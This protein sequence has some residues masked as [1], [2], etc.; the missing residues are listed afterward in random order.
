[1]AGARLGSAMVTAAVAAVLFTTIGCGS[2]PV[3]E[4]GPD[5][6]AISAATMRVRADGCGPRT[7]LG[8]GT[9]IVDGLVVTAAHVVAGAQRVEVVDRLGDTIASDVV[10]FDPELDVAALRPNRDV[11][12]PVPVRAERGRQG[13]NGLVALIAADG[14]VTMLEVD[15]LQ[16]VTIDTTDIYRGEPVRRNGL[17]VAVTVAPGDSGAMV[18]L[19]GGGAGIVWSRSMETSDQAWT[20]DL[21][22]ELLDAP[23][24]RALGTPVDTG[25]CR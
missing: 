2:E 9:V 19:P 16:R 20:V 4:P 15:V 21:P 22:S 5:R 13:D 18:H 23:L 7:E 6:Q 8:T 25:P 3:S 17:R 11:G 1:M 12:P 24:R 10:L 14:S